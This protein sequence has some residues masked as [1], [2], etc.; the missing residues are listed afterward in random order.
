M[1]SAELETLT[2]DPE[3]SGWVFRASGYTVTFPGY[4]AV[5]EEAADDGQRNRRA[6]DP[7]EQRDLR[8]P[9]PA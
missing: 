5:Y 8:I 6:D 7:E 4:M 2:V 9:P 3:C 1:E